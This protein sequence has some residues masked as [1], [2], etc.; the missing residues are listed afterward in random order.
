MLLYPIQYRTGPC[1]TI[2]YVTSHAFPHRFLSNIFTQLNNRLYKECNLHFFKNLSALCV[3]QL[4]VQSS[5]PKQP[6]PAP[7]NKQLNPPLSIERA[8]LRAS[9]CTGSNKYMPCKYLSRKKT[10]FKA[11]LTEK[12]D[13]NQHNGE[14][15]SLLPVLAMLCCSMK[16]NPFSRTHFCTKS[17]AAKGKYEQYWTYFYMEIIFRQSSAFYNVCCMSKKLNCPKRQFPPHQEI[18]ADTAHVRMFPNFIYML[19]NSILCLRKNMK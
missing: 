1:N 15:R 9:N 11:V 3:V 10:G 2:S 18:P 19:P 13:A 17:F 6:F 4:V 8:F 14:C 12:Y 5:D 7:C 16:F